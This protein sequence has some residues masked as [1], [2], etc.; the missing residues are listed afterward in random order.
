M[1]GLDDLAAVSQAT[2]PK[3]AAP[4]PYLYPGSALADGDYVLW[5]EA[6]QESDFNASHN[7]PNAPDA[8]QAWD[9]EGHPFL[10]QPSVVYR[11]PFHLDRAGAPPL[12]LDFAGY[13]TWDGSDGALHAPDGTITTATPGTGAGRLATPTVTVGTCN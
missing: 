13:S 3:N 7:H 2:P 6:S 12:T 4:P 1:G 8:T 5:I 9:F 10:G 11:A